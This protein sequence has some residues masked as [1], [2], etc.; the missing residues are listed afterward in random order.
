MNISIKLHNDIINYK[1]TLDDSIYKIDKSKDGYTIFYK[2]GRAVHSKYNIEVECKR[3][4]ECINK[5]LIIVYGYGLGYIVK[6]LTD[7]IYNYFTNIDNLQIIVIVDDID[8][9]IYSYKN[10]FSSFNLSDK[11]YFLSSS[12]D[13]NYIYSLID[14]KKVNGVN[15]VLLPS[16]SKEEKDYANKIYIDI[17]HSIEREVSNIFTNMYFENIWTKNI[18]FNSEY[19]NNSFDISSLKNIFNGLCALL[20]C[21]GPTLRFSILKIKENRDNLIIICVDTA[22]AVLLKYGITPDFVVTV[23]GGFYN[24]LDFVY[25]DGNF[26]YLVMDIA[27]NKIIPKNICSRANIIRF[28]STVNLGI[29]KDIN[30]YIPIS[31]LTTSNTV[32]TTMIEFAYYVGFDRVLLIG[33]DNSYPFYERHSKHS[34]SYEYKINNIN[35]LDTIESYYFDTIRHNT[36]ISHYPPTE[37]VL[38]EQIEYFKFTKYDNFIIE[39]VTLNAINIDCFKEGSIDDYILSDTRETIL[40]KMNN[41]LSNSY[42]I[43]NFYIYLEDSLISF[44]EYIIDI[45]NK[46]SNINT[47]EEFENIFMSIINKVEFEKCNTIKTILDNALFLSKRGEADYK[48]KLLFIILESTKVLNYFLTRISMIK[49]K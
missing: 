48:N 34:L 46:L 36:D 38:N 29:I 6:Y 9:F 27:C 30:N 32:T 19:L 10:I 37:F 18:I 24:S 26:P 1:N 8:L 31:E 2:N 47:E 20:I 39:R 25:A 4:L 23:D 17:L 21:P 11:I 33:F 22:L 42:D 13:I 45:Y 49:N 16:L 3:A 12:E 15:L 40:E 5:N 43:K 14:Y 44:R 41:I 35:K 28:T 7:N